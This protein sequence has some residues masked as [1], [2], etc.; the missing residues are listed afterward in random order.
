MK[1]AT[2]KTTVQLEVANLTLTQTMDSSRINKAME[3]AFLIHLRIGMVEMPILTLIMGWD[4]DRMCIKYKT[5]MLMG[6]R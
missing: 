1:K 2:V 5:I 6:T 4:K 3:E